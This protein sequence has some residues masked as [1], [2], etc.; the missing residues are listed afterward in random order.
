MI[1]CNGRGVPMEK[2]WL[3]SSAPVRL[4]L[5]AMWT[6]DVATGDKTWRII[7]SIS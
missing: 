2:I 6:P 7:H 5:V 4:Q 1:N 3:E